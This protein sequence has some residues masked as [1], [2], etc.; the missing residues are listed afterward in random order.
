[1]YLIGIVVPSLKALLVSWIDIRAFP[2]LLEFSAREQALTNIV[3]PNNS[4]CLMTDSV[5]ICILASR[6]GKRFVEQFSF[7]WCI[8]KR[9]TNPA[10]LRLVE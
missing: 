9:I 2:P 6:E 5:D 4:R 10:D 8:A 1:V 3:M 7:I